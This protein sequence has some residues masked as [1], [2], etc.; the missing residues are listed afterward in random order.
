MAALSLHQ[1]CGHKPLPLP[2]CGFSLLFPPQ[3]LIPRPRSWPTA[4]TDQAAMATFHWSW[5][6]GTVA[7]WGHWAWSP[8]F[9]IPSVPPAQHLP[10]PAAGTWQLP[11]LHLSSQTC[12]I[13]PGCEASGLR[14]TCVSG[15][16][17]SA[18]RC[19]RGLGA[20]P[21]WCPLCPLLRAS[22]AVEGLLTRHSY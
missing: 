7:P 16:T 14:A 1:G 4:V 10:L 21:Q 19:S 20:S 13:R 5:V 8:P 3:V 11:T 9:F 12:Q 2:C 15:V 18:S 22:E 17:L 6:K